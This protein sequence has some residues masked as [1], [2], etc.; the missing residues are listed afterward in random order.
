MPAP[1]A[2]HSRA[3]GA[4][5]GVNGAAVAPQSGDIPPALDVQCTFSPQGRLCAKQ[6]RC[7]G[8]AT[9]YDYTHDERGHLTEARRDGQVAERYTYNTAGQRIT[10]RVNPL[11]GMSRDALRML[12]T[13]RAFAY[14]NAGRLVRAGRA[15]YMYAPDDTLRCREEGRNNTWF[16]YDNGGNGGNGDNR[17]NAAGGAPHASPGPYSPYGPYGPHGQLAPVALDSVV[18]PGGDI[19]RY[20][21]G[22][23]GMPFMVLRNHAPSEEYQWLD[24]LRLARFRDHRTGSD[25]TFHYG[26]DRVPEAVTVR[27]PALDS[28][29]GNLL[30]P[31]I[32]RKAG[33][34][35]APQ[36]SVTFRIGCDQVGTPKALL[37]P[38]G[39]VVKRM[40]Y[41]SFGN[42]LL[43]TCVLLPAAGLCRRAGGPAHRPRAV[44]LSRLRPAHRTLHR[45]RPAGRHRRRPRPLRLLRGRS[46]QRLRPAGAGGRG[47]LEALAP[48]VVIPLRKQGKEGRHCQNAGAGGTPR[49]RVRNGRRTRR[50]KNKPTFLGIRGDS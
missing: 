10:A 43:D 22:D 37:A 12:E 14:D 47:H 23:N 1:N 20:R 42:P 4:P 36:R 17:G 46:G 49:T 19:I 26:G 5:G 31:S 21:F 24:P 11:P 48:L 34:P 30:D 13:A 16:Y 28:L 2:P 9:S 50:Q 38:D 3:E 39:R 18:L 27:G 6:E 7:G 41:D 25:Y 15:R 33:E 29:D 32:F 8:R 45:A 40:V 44:R 35:A